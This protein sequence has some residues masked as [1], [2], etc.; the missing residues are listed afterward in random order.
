MSVEN[1]ACFVCGD[2][3]SMWSSYACYGPIEHVI[4]ESCFSMSY[5]VTK[6]FPKCLCT[7]DFILEKD[8]NTLLRPFKSRM[9][10]NVKKDL[11][12]CRFCNKSMVLSCLEDHLLYNNMCMDGIQNLLKKQNPLAGILL[13]PDVTQLKCNCNI[14][15]IDEIIS[16][17]DKD[18]RILAKFVSCEKNCRRVKWL[19]T[20]DVIMN[21]QWLSVLQETLI[22]EKN[23]KFNLNL[24]R[25]R[26]RD[27]I[28]LNIDWSDEDDNDNNDNDNDDNDDDYAP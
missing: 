6:K 7:H 20:Q 16:Y 25:K 9:V 14:N 4:C 22:R 23:N 19:R 3:H 24:N 8:K 5:E 21:D 17:N 11:V 13:K 28:D 15:N 27:D 1:H 18:G 2:V 10:G 12:T 26:K